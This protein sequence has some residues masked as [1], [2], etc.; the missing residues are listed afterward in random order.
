MK[1]RLILTKKCQRS[2][3]GCCNEYEQM[4][5]TMKTV[6][7]EY[8]KNHSQVMITGGEPMLYPNMIKNIISELRKQNPTRKI[9]LYTALYRKV[10]EEIILLVDGIHYTIH[11]NPSL[12][13]IS[14]FYKFQKLIANH[15]GSYRAYI[16]QNVKDTIYVKPNVWSRFEIKQ[17][18]PEGACDLPNGEELLVL[19]DP[20][21]YDEKY[22]G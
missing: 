21:K 5:A 22:V 11:D 15:K 4:K 8:V 19:S 6:P 7:L 16:D 2:C 3:P 1:A 14:G 13:D 12:N 20:E 9:Y 17:W 10:M 18:I